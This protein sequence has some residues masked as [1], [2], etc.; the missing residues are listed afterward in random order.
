MYVLL[1]QLRGHAVT[2]RSSIGH[3]IW[4][5]RSQFTINLNFGM[6]RNANHLHILYA[7]MEVNGM[8]SVV[9]PAPKNSW[10]TY[11]YKIYSS[12][13]ILNG[14]Y[15][16]APKLIGEK[17]L[18]SIPYYLLISQQ[19]SRPKCIL[20]VKLVF[21]DGCSNKTDCNSILCCKWCRNYAFCHLQQCKYILQLI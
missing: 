2:Y 9:W 12:C 8:K 3:M 19:M 14:Q 10:I 15:F 4:I 13:W 17:G 11:E 7:W 6:Q 16:F 5:Y 20:L 21:Y 18:F 1:I